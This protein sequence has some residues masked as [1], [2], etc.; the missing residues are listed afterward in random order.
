MPPVA[1]RSLPPPEA[2]AGITNRPKEAEDEGQQRVE[3][4][5]DE[6]T[7]FENVNRAR[8]DHPMDKD[9]EHDLE[10]RGRIHETGV[11]RGL[12]HKGH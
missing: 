6:L 3:E 1:A 4:Q 8:K 7:D 10:S 2:M 12:D 9:R 5:K 11:G